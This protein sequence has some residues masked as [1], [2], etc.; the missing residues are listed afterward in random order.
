MAAA[1]QSHV[2]AAVEAVLWYLHIERRRKNATEGFA[3]VEKMFSLYA[4]LDL[5]RG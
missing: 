3:S 1:K 2:D 5:A 4:Q